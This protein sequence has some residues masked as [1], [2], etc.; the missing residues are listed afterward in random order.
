M[1]SNTEV[2]LAWRAG[3]SGWDALV[4]RYS[5]LVW[6]VP[7]SFRLSQTDAADVYQCTWLCLAEHLTRLREPDYLATWLVR[8]ATRQSIA[9]LRTRGREVSYDLWEP[10]SVLPSP[11]EVAITHDRQR[12]LWSALM[13]LNERCQRLL[14]IAAHSPELS[15][16][17]VADALGIKLGSVGS[18]RS[19]CL[20]DLRRKLED[21]R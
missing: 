14:R 15:Y 20:A 12:R 5:R 11:D 13:T 9:V 6:S 7:R 19:R 3:L 18:T 2:L 17:Q 1:D 8:T 4:D 10:V 16:A 21:L